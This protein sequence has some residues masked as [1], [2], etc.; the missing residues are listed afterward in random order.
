[1]KPH[2]MLRFALATI[3]S[4]PLLFAG[5]GGGVGTGGTGSAGT[6]VAGPITG[7]GSVI[8]NDIR[9]DDSGATVLDDEGG[10]RQR[11]DLR[12][13]MTVEIDG[14]E[15]AAGGAG[16][17]STA[18]RI[19]FG[20]AMVGPVEAVD[21]AAG[22]LVVLGQTVRVAVET[23]FDDRLAG[24]LA[25]L[26][27]GLVLEVYAQYDAAA[28]AFRATRIGP[29]DVAIGWQLRAPVTALDTAARTLRIGGVTFF[30]G[31][32]APPPAALAVG[33]LVKLRIALVPDDAGR[34]VVTGFGSVLRP[35]EDRASAR[36]RGLVT[37]YASPARFE[38]DGLP[39]D[40]SGVAVQGGKGALQVGA[41]VEVRGPLVAGVLRATELKLETDDDVRDR[42]FELRG[43]IESIDTAARTFRLRGTTVGYA[44]PDLRVDNGTLADLAVGRRVEVKAHPSP[45]RTRLDAV[46]LEFE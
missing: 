38:V 9:F 22:T 36:L 35:P 28:Q 17:T 20:S 44:R 10:N 39:V 11:S 14:D 42:G 30:Y 4:L 40:A 31:S 26:E 18:T 46:R 5:C 43:T 34:H 21:A 8:V 7:F 6:Y 1:M 19:R 29:V 2:S 24:G 13:G 15:V 23:V 33:Q 27:P 41:R 32:A 25:A 37:A 12:L 16:A 3:V 45:D